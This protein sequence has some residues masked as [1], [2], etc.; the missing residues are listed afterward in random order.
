MLKAVSLVGLF[1]MIAAIVGLYK[2]GSLLSWNPIAIALQIVAVGLMVWARVTFKW[3]S[4]HASA[5]PTVGGLVR[6]GPYRYI[7]HPI[8]T[9]A[10]VFGWAGAL[11]HLSALSI[12]WGAALFVGGLTRM[13]CEE[14][15][16]SH[17]FP[18]YRDY[19]KTTKR[20]LP[21]VF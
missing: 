5:D 20:M 13:L 8:Y 10:C 7:R 17:A 21:Y 3:R 9:A 4:F 6:T 1:V 14:R 15:L 19:A 18:E 16:L 2:I 12:A 11:A